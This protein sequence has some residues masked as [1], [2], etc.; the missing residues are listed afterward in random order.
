MGHELCEL[1]KSESGGVHY[2]AHPPREQWKGSG[3][4]R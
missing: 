2:Y 1:P 3:P 4:R